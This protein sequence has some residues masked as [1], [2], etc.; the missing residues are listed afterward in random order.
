VVR[1]DSLE[2]CIMRVTDR[3]D[4]KCGRMAW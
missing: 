1:I 3:V 4:F 2:G